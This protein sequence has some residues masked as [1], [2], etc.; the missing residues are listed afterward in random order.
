MLQLDE[1]EA[2]IAI[3]NPGVGSF[4][5][6]RETPRLEH[7]RRTTDALR[8][9][10]REVIAGLW[11]NREELLA[12]LN[13]PQAWIPSKYFYDSL[14]SQ[15]FTAITHLPEYYPTRSEAA[16]FSRHI[17]DIARVVGSGRNLIDLGAGNCEKAASLFEALKPAQ[18][19][20]VDISAAYL[21]TA[22]VRLRHQF[23]DIGMTGLGMDMSEGLSLPASVPDARRLFFYPGSSIG[24]FTP[25]DAAGFL[26]DLRR[27]CQQQGGLLIGVDLVK[28]KAIL[29]AAYDDALGVTAAFNLNALNNVNSVLG[30]D[31]D[32]RDW[33]HCG[34]F[35]QTQSR[36]EM[37][38]ET[39][40]EIEVRWPGGSRRFEAG[41]R[42][43]TENSY[44]YSLEE[45]GALLRRTGFRKVTAW[46][47]QRNWFALFY[48]T[49]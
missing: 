15:L 27:Q 31:F 29:D 37:H 17:D 40:L 7:A 34:F 1:T 38:V 9:R 42:I 12:G 18:Y 26:S 23:P 3:A 41:E 11:N 43:H 36:A 4:E 35:N 30:S 22:L 14:G 39:R 8:F 25:A 20:A 5:R 44:K 46:T 28:E 10:N 45:F 47:D 33:R 49:A 6:V 24:N 48:A 19:I 32:V 21:E 13:A 2:A 16:I